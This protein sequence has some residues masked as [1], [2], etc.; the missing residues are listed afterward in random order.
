MYNPCIIEQNTLL[1]DATTF[2]NQFMN[3]VNMNFNNVLNM[4][5]IAPIRVLIDETSENLSSGH[6]YETDESYRGFVQTQKILQLKR[7]LIINTKDLCRLEENT[8]RAL[9]YSKIK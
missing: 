9:N 1:N 7:D 6:S 3:L 2:K 4:K 8:L 5:K